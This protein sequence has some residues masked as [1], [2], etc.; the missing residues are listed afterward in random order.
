MLKTFIENAVN[1]FNLFP[2]YF[3]KNEKTPYSVSKKRFQ[4]KSV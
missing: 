4:V 1:V 2:V 3:L